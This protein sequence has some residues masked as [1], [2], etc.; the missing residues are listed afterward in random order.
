[1]STDTLDQELAALDRD[2]ADVKSHLDAIYVNH[3]IPSG[4]YIVDYEHQL[5]RLYG[6]RNKLRLAA[7]KEA[8]RAPTI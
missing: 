1:M 2:I 3:H 7:E 5:T 8:R 6:R 4:R